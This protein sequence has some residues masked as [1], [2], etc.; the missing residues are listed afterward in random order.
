[1]TQHLLSAG[2]NLIF[3]SFLF[4]QFTD[5]KPVS[6][7]DDVLGLSGAFCMESHCHSE[8][9]QCRKSKVCMENLACNAYCVA[10]EFPSD[11]TIQ[12]AHGQ[13]C[14]LKCSASYQNQVTDAFN[15]CMFENECINLPKIN[16]TCPAGLSRH[17]QPNSSL[18]SMSGEWWQHYGH[19]PLWDCYPCQHIH[20]MQLVN[21]TVWEYTYSSD[22]YLVNNS[23]KY[24]YQTLTL[25][26]PAKG[27]P[28]EIEYDY[29][30]SGMKETWFILEAT[31]RYVVV[32]VCS[33]ISSWTNVDNPVWV[34][35]N[36]TLTAAEMKSIAAVSQRA[37]GWMFPDQFCKLPYESSCV[38][39]ASN[40]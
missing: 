37:L 22:I 21:D 19:N 5:G 16:V 32:A 7:Q 8:W 1:M 26:N 10:I 17:I 12:K 29:M 33:W 25:P 39:P 36:V 20:S 18:H 34:R 13:N 27:Q 31:E 11:H 9:V 4:W 6:F 2:M 24:N 40:L 30:G 28:V 3:I 35:P 23:L 15:G 14:T 38:E